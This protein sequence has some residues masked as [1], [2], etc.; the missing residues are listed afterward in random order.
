MPPKRPQTSKQRRAAQNRAA[1][2]ALAARR[3]SAARRP[4]K[5]SEEPAPAPARR[6]WFGAP[7]PD[8]Q[9][10]RPDRPPTFLERVAPERFALVGLVLAVIA[11]AALLLLP[12]VQV[13]GTG[14][15]ETAEYES[16]L[17]N[18]GL[19]AVAF[20]AVPV[21]IAALG[22]WAARPPRRPKLL[23][24]AAFAQVACVIISQ[25]GLFFLFSAALLGLAA[26]RVRRS[27]SVD[28]ADAEA[29]A[30]THSAE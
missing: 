28:P 29:P 4:A 14:R 16:L 9:A 11:S 7:A 5:A 23:I 18:A 8:R 22:S 27:P 25:A 10:S 1:R 6:R 13:E 21:T 26:W 2:E 24:G 20:V 3:E 15:G 19:A 30:E 12:L 17:A